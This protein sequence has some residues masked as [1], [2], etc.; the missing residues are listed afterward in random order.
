ML[1]RQ[2]TQR[3]TA[4]SQFKT[5]LCWIHVAPGPQGVRGRWKRPAHF[6]QGLLDDLSWV[7]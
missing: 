1:Q 5:G 7:S 2:P 4:L 3:R 6:E